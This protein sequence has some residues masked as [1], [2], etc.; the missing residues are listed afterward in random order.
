MDEANVKGPE[1]L[2]FHFK[3]KAVYYISIRIATHLGTTG[4]SFSWSYVLYLV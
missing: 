1:T 4:V 2:N 3:A